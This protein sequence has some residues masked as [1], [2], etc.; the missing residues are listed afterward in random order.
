MARYRRSLFGPIA[1][2]DF[3]FLSYENPWFHHSTSEPVELRMV[4]MVAAFRKSIF[5]QK[6]LRFSMLSKLNRFVSPSFSRQEMSISRRF[7]NMEHP[8]SSGSRYHGFAAAL[9]SSIRKA[10]KLQ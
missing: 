10:M 2:S 6:E 7:A 8:T 4:S 3:L 1:Y 9:P 5:A